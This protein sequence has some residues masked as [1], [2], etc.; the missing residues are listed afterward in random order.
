MNEENNSGLITLQLT[1]IDIDGTLQPRVDGLD[2]EQ[3]RALESVPDSWPPIAVVKQKGK[4]R[5]VDGFHRYAAAQNLGLEK[6]SVQVLDLPED[7]DLHALAFELNAVHG[8]PLNLSDRRAFAVRLLRQHSEWSDREIGRRCGLSQPPVAKLRKHL[9]TQQE[10]EPT[11]TRIGRGGL[12][13]RVTEPANK[14]DLGS[15][16]ALETSLGDR[17]GS[18]LSSEQRRQQR[19]IAQYLQRLSVSLQDQDQL[20]SWQTATDAVEACR[21]VLGE[22]KAGELAQMLGD[23]S[24]NVLEV[25]RRLGH[26]E[27]E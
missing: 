20:E 1:S 8:R 12:V 13:Y 7:G 25:A 23:Y 5:L 3:I 21:A 15:L 26:A 18:L 24:L 14:R 16:P 10:I 2:P 17:V 6:I 11:E 19:L 22:E 9:E 27:T 4:N